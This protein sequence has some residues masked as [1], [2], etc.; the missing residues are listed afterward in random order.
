[1]TNIK[2]TREYQ[3]AIE[4]YKRQIESYLMN[5][6]AP[7]SATKEQL[8]AISKTLSIFGMSPT[9]EREMIRDLRIELGLSTRKA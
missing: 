7:W 2:E 1:M 6:D 3:L 9:E 5:R 4:N 8:E